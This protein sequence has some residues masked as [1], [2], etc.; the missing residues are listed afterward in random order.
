MENSNWSK[1]AR[2]VERHVV[3]GW[4]DL[5]IPSQAQDAARWTVELY[6]QALAWCADGKERHGAWRW[7]AV[8]VSMSM[9]LP[10]GG[11]LNRN[12]THTEVGDANKIKSTFNFF[13][14][15]ISRAGRGL[16]GVEQHDQWHCVVN[17]PD[18]GGPCLLLLPFFASPTTT[19]RF[20]RK[21]P[22]KKR[23]GV[24]ACL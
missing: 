13:S 23:K 18:P 6:S 24:W 7:L 8:T 9:P 14:T 11:R 1:Q 20:N 4:G 22:E 17:S 16:G 19:G 3:S 15:H 2:S 12:E 10:A 5:Y 21:R